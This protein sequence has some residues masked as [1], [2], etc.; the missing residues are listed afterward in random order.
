MEVYLQ[1]HHQ[2]NWTEWLLLITF[3]W[4]AKINPVTKLSLFEVAHRRQS[5][6]GM[7]PTQHH[8]DGQLQQANVMVERMQKV[9][10]E[11]EAAL[12]NMK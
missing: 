8:S 6:L 12:E 7:E 9:R 10:E 3:S 4:N 2:N 5:R 1:I 11:A